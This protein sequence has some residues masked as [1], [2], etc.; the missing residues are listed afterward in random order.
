MLTKPF[1]INLRFHMKALQ[2]A[3]YRPDISQGF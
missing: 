2:K 3:L 1:N